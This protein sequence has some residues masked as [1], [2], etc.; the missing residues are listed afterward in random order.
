[1]CR[2]L[3]GKVDIVPRV[4]RSALKKYAQVQAN[5]GVGFPEGWDILDL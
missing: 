5:I 1:M 3:F 2:I 4:P